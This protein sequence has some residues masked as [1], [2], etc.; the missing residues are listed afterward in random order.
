[1]Q[2]QLITTY[3][4]ST[5]WPKGLHRLPHAHK[6]L[7]KKKA[8]IYYTAPP[9]AILRSFDLTS[10]LERPGEVPIHL[11]YNKLLNKHFNIHII[12]T[13]DFFTTQHIIKIMYRNKTKK[14]CL[15][16]WQTRYILRY[17][18]TF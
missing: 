13:P 8:L 2:K 12:S 15:A 17:F 16:L 5:G 11:N 10:P 3:A 6:P 18:E 9:C 1:M 14:N 7:C 4:H